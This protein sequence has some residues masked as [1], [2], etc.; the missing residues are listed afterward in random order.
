M[1]DHETL[2]ARL[3]EI[4]AYLRRIEANQKQSD[5][6]T[7]LDDLEF[8]LKDAKH[9]FETGEAQEFLIQWTQEQ[10]ALLTES[11]PS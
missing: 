5:S 3:T 1:T 6:L 11:S 4:R 2:L 8:Y 10:K 7:F 9:D